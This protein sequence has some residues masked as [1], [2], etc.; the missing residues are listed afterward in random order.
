ARDPRRLTALA[1]GARVARHR[2]PGRLEPERTG[3]VDPVIVAVIALAAAVVLL[4]AALV[5]RSGFRLRKPKLGV[6][7]ILLPFAGGSLDPTVLNAAIRI[8]HAESATLVPAYLLIVPLRYSEDSPLKDEVAVAMPLLEA[9]ERAA[10]RAGV[11]VDA[12][13]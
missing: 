2:H 9:V 10:T 4:A 1:H 12:R 11:P 5:V 6:Q 13:I 3:S 7:R 8:A